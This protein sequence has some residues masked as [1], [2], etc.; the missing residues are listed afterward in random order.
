[1]SPQ[2]GLEIGVI[3][4]TLNEKVRFNPV[5][6]SEGVKVPKQSS[7]CYQRVMINSTQTLPRALQQI[8]LWPDCNLVSFPGSVG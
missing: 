1:M 4:L 5:V 8:K 2:P 6:N 7:D 3:A